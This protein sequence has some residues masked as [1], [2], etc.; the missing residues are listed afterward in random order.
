MMLASLVIR[1]SNRIRR[2]FDD[3]RFGVLRIY[4]KYTDDDRHVIRSLQRIS[5]PGLRRYVSAD[6]IP[7]V[8][9]GLGI[10]ILSTSRGV[11]T[12]REARQ[13]RVGGELLATVY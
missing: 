5:K 6:D 1:I 11:M 3:G 12:G 10:S 9:S 7:R 4:L 2:N 8:L 13:E